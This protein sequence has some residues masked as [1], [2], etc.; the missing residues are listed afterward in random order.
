MALLLDQYGH[1]NEL[2]ERIAARRDFLVKR[3]VWSIGGDGWAYDI[4][5]GGLDHILA[6]GE[7]IN[8]FV[9]D[10][11]VYS[12]T[13]GQSSKA[14]PAGCVAKLNA[15]GKKT[16]K[17]DLGLMAMTYGNVYVAQ[18]A[19]GADYNQTLRA[20]TEA[21]KYRGPSLLIAYAP[22]V[23]HGIKTGMGT[24]I[25]EE[26]KA[27]D[28]GYWHLYRFNPELRKEGKP[29]IFDSG[30]IKTKGFKEFIQGEIRYSQLMNVFPERAL[31]CLNLPSSMPVRGAKGTGGFR[32]TLF[33][34][35]G[36]TAFFL[37][38]VAV[39][40]F[41][42]IPDINFVGLAYLGN[43]FVFFHIGPG[44]SIMSFHCFRA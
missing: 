11:E 22:C 5:Y 31:K 26:R 2:L 33:K 6:S 37:F 17:K 39:N 8:I 1:G 30:K 34:K 13:G 36:L 44:G 18:I 4:G 19:M 9:M 32:G 29:F 38:L 28:A 21:E 25:Q 24:S 40:I 42:G 3:S 23:S 15:A 41:F 20:M 10:T 43:R 12:N 35:E 7:D 27:V 16:R 14:T